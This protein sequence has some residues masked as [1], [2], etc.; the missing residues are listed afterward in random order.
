MKKYDREKHHRRSIRLQGYDYT[1]QG[2]YFVTMVT[3]NRT[4]LFGDIAEEKIMLNEGG[5]I[6]HQCWL[7]IP[8]H[9]PHA[10]LD[11]FVIMPN[12][13]HGILVI[14]GS[15]LSA[16]SYND[17]SAGA[18]YFSPPNNH[19]STNYHSPTNDIPV[20]DVGM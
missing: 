11:E 8:Q 16:H 17:V 6:A 3:Q 20:N 18:K 1:S 15:H 5:K 4:C 13:V 7:D 12:H 10:S 14:T 2:A 9:F 19:L